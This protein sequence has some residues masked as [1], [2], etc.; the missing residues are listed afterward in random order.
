MEQRE[1]GKPPSLSDKEQQILMQKLHELIANKKFPTLYDI[2]QICVQMF[3]KLISVYTIRN[4]IVD[5]DDFKIIDGEPQDEDRVN[6]DVNSIDNYYTNLGMHVNGVPASLVF[7][8]DEAGQDEYVGTHSMKV[9]VNSSYKGTTIKIPVRRKTKR[10]TLVHCICY[11][12]TYAKPL[13]II[14]R[15]T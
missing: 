2:E 5:S 6:V 10:P 15:K 7:N 4:Y 11:D 3:H 8:M 9:I 12:G 1:N 13:I 14:P